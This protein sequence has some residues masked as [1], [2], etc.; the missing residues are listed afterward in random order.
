MPNFSVANLSAQ[1]IQPTLSTVGTSQPAFDITGSLLGLNP[2]YFLSSQNS[3]PGV[4]MADIL[5]PVPGYLVNV[6]KKRKFVDFVMLRPCNL[7]KLP[8]VEPVG[9]Q[10]SRLLRCEK[11]SELKPIQCFS[12]W[13]EA[14]A[15]YAG[16]V[17]RQRPDRLSDLIGYFVL[18]SKT[19][20]DTANMDWLDYDRAFR[21]KAAGVPGL[22]WSAVD[23]SLF[24]S[25][26]LGKAEK[27][28]GFEAKPKINVGSSDTRSKD[29]RKICMGFNNGSCAFSNCRYKH[30]CF[31]CKGDHKIMV[32]P[33]FRDSRIEATSSSGKRERS[34]SPIMSKKRSSK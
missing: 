5:P 29:V 4:S 14:W 32:C 31:G 2:Q 11:G 3:E 7:D 15:V 10:L 27:A 20:N 9:P 19:S 17:S 8:S 1:G 26:I 22:V 23:M 34:P 13:A 18:I 25:T 12:E 30:I 6:I 33:Q 24:V 28:D 21:K 16:V